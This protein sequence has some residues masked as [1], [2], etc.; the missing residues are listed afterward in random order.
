MMNMGDE[1]GAV[2]PGS[3]SSGIAV[4]M[5]EDAPEG[6]RGE[7]AQRPRTPSSPQVDFLGFDASWL[8]SLV[9]A[10]RPGGNRAPHGSGA[11][12]SQSGLHHGFDL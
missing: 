2:G 8:A 12:A 4:A 6:H 10:A 1:G 5:G 7:E 9:L 11:H 3:E